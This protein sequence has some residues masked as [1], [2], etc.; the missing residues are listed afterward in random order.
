VPATSPDIVAVV[1]PPGDHK[2]PNGPVPPLTVALTEPLLIPKQVTCI[3]LVKP[4]VCPAA[5]DCIVRRIAQKRVAS[6]FMF[7]FL[8]GTKGVKRQAQSI[9]I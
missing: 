4:T 6:S 9:L 3:I 2:Y 5:K 1:C 8:S 7:S